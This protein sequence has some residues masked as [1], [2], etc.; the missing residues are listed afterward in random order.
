MKNLILQ[1]FL[2][3]SSIPAF[4]QAPPN[5]PYFKFINYK[6]CE[7][8]W[9]VRNSHKRADYYQFGF[10]YVDKAK[11]FVF[12]Q[13]GVF[14]VDKDGR[15]VVNKRSLKQKHTRDEIDVLQR[16]WA[17]AFPYEWTFSPIPPERFNDLKIK[18]AVPDW[19]K[20]Y[21]N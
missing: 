1:L 8:Q 5:D 9:V 2:L 21:Y 15:Y 4:S 20:K 16:K 11:G 14:F 13:S 19:V 6:F 10:M 3:A 12:Q 17:A 18:Q 7:K